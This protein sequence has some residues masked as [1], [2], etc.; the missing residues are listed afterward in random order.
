[1]GDGFPF[2]DVALFALVAGFLILRLRT[3]LGRRDGHHSRAPDP[4]AQAK[5]ERADDKV[6]RLPERNERPVETVVSPADTATAVTPLEAGLTQVKIADP[7][8][9]P[10]EFLSGAR[11][12]FEY[13]LNAF[14]AGESERLQELLSP[15][16]NANFAHSI[17]ARQAARQRLETRLVAITAASLVEAYMVGR[18]AHLTVKFDSDQV[19]ALYDA[20]GAVIEGDP[21][22]VVEVIDFWT[23]ARDTRS[24]DPNWMLVA[25]GS[26]E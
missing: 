4:F 3:V 21:D 9:D 10:A 15:E 26:A 13:I 24:T 12:A 19:S 14:A 18:T 20:E 8:F 7:R 2:I 11:I 1:M 25:T 6:A 16:V 17:R 23:F 22:Q 5:T